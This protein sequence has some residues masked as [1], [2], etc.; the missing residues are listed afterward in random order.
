VFNHIA[1][2]IFSHLF[3]LDKYV[4]KI[5]KAVKMQDQKQEQMAKNDTG[6]MVKHFDLSTYLSLPHAASI[7]IPILNITNIRFIYSLLLP[8]SICKRSIMIDK[9]NWAIGVNI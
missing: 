2:I 4:D 6:D 1:C 3:L 9:E 8:S 7:N 5:D